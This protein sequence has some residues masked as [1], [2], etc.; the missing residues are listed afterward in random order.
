M[1]KLTKFYENWLVQ[2]ANKKD[3]ED[4]SIQRAY[5]YVE[6]LHEAGT[7]DFGV[8]AVL[9][10]N[11]GWLESHIKARRAPAAYRWFHAAKWWCIYFGIRLRTTAVTIWEDMTYQPPA[12]EYPCDW[13]FPDERVLH[14]EEDR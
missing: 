4:D 8:Q 6:R 13:P 11:I 9:K 12:N 14:A 3:A 1:P 2:L 7:I 5:D 10:S